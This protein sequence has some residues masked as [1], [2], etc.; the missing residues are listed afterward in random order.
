MR[1]RRFVVTAALLSTLAFGVTSASP[2]SAQV[3]YRH[4]TTHGYAPFP[5][6][7]PSP[8]DQTFGT[9]PSFEILPSPYGYAPGV[10]VVARCLYPNGWNVTDFGRDINGIPPGIDHT[11]PEGGPSAPLHERY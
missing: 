11:C 6:S 10:R 4:G 5:Y 9:R 8:Y 3:T 2:A 7:D 1:V